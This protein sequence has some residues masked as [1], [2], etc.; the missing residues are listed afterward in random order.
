[1][2]R[3]LPC[4]FSWAPQAQTL[5]VCLSWE[6]ASKLRRESRLQSLWPSVLDNQPCRSLIL[7]IEAITFSMTCNVNRN[8]GLRSAIPWDQWI[9]CSS[10][11]VWYVCTS[12]MHEQSNYFETICRSYYKIANLKG[13]AQEHAQSLANRPV[14][15]HQGGR[16]LTLASPSTKAD[17]SVVIKSLF[18]LKSMERRPWWTSARIGHHPNAGNRNFLIV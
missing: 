2:L 1:M 9:T 14:Y 12:W 6:Y 13:D 7:W 4:L 11:R 3:N 8:H 5:R 17:G 18:F 15:H 16:S 10:S